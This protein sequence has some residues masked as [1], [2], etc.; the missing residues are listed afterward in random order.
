M[1]PRDSVS[2]VKHG[3]LEAPSWILYDT[4]NTIYS[5]SIGLLLMKFLRETFHSITA[6]TVMQTIS[7]VLSGLSIPLFAALADRTGKAKRYMIIATAIAVAGM[8]MWGVSLSL[9]VILIAFAVSNFAYNSA[10]VFYNSLLPSVTTPE[11]EGIVSGFGVGLGYIGTLLVGFVLLSNLDTLGYQNVF[12]LGSLL[13]LLLAIPSFVF[14]RER[15]VRSRARYSKT[16]VRRSW[17][18]LLSTL[19][20]LPKDRNMM[21][22]LIGNFFCVD[23]LNTAILVFLTYSVAVFSGHVVEI[24]GVSYDLRLYVEYGKLTDFGNA[25]VWQPDGASFATLMGVALPILA[26]FMGI[27]TGWLSE[28]WGSAKTMRLSA[29]SLLGGLIAG[30]FFVG[31]GPENWEMRQLSELAAIER[32]EQLAST[33]DWER[34]AIGIGAEIDFRDDSDE[35]RA[36]ASEQAKLVDDKGDA[37]VPDL[38]IDT[39]EL[40]AWK[41]SLYLFFMVGFG[42]L[43]LAGIWTAGRKLLIDISPRQRL[44][45]YFGL[46]GITVKVSVIGSLLF[47]LMMDGIGARWAMLSIA[48]PLLAGIFCLTKVKVEKRS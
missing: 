48:L 13:F 15:R 32:Q 11:K 35:L 3:P 42:S 43:G 22:F 14:V 2:P 6:P 30:V 26:L 41:P 33:D 21:W 24:F 38:R 36:I 45:E 18:R 19:R 28:R 27:V 29:V 12:M 4:A 8:F 23:V 1:V 10:L 44:G 39:G 46:Y 20:R 34:F 47:G 37:V 25:R 7:M 16:L 5:A 9:W 17:L 31:Q 40:S